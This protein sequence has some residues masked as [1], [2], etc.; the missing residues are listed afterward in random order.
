MWYNT[1]MKRSVL[2]LLLATI[3]VSPVSAVDL[4]NEQKGAIS[5]NCNSIKTSLKS[6]QKTDS[7]TRVLLG[8][9]YQTI[10]T[11]FLTPLNLRL[12]KDNQPNTTLSTIQTNLASERNVFQEQFI[13]YSQQLEELISID[14]QNHPEDFYTK[15]QAT[16]K[17]R[18]QL[19]RSA[20][21][22]NSLVDKHLATVNAL[23]E[24]E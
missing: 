5:Q 2:T 8:T 4:S 20:I 17:E 3:L 10:L 12:V 19:N 24:K 9:S 14:C 21:H 1:I 15:L 22:I 16:R 13:K 18:T 23:K 6:L 11:N 7:R